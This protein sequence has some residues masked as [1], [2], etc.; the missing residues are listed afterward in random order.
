VKTLPE[1]RTALLSIIATR[2]GR[3]RYA[4]LLS[5]TRSRAA[6]DLVMALYC[7]IDDW[8]TKTNRRKRRRRST[9]VFTGAL[10]RLVGDLLRARAARNATGRIFHALGRMTFD[11]VP[12]SY[13]VFNGV[14]IGLQGLSYL[15][16]ELGTR[17]SAR[18]TAFWAT[19]KLLQ[20]AEEFGIHL[21]NINDHFKP[22]PPHH[23]LVLRGPTTVRH[24][25]F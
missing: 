14:F 7:E 13:K 10:Q 25:S 22:E 21:S 18:T 24:Q 11:D 15:G 8:E 5:R 9:E 12:V 6:Q 16:V 23:P 4:A 20:R 2:S 17:K 3:D 1:A 19:D